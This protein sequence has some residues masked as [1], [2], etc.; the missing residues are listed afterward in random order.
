M[1]FRKKTGREKGKKKER[2]ALVVPGFSSLI[3]SETG[4]QLY[5]LTPG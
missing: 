4:L 1:C 3:S 5:Y 2:G